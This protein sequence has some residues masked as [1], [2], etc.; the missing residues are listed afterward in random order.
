MKIQNPFRALKF[1]T[2]LKSDAGI[3]VGDNCRQHTLIQ[4]V[5]LEWRMAQAI[6]VKI[7]RMFIAQP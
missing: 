2:A 6:L 5:I 7:P 4:S 1:V 3:L